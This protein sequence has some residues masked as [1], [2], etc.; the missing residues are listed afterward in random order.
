[1]RGLSI[2]EVAR[3]AG[4]APSAVRYYERAGL[5]PKPPRVSGRRRYDPEIVGRL[6]IIRIARDSGFTIAETRIFVAGFPAGMKPSARWRSLAERKLAEIDATIA[7]AEQM[8]K[9]LTTQFN[10]RCETIEDCE[11]AIV[12]TRCG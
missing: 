5:L 8:K 1:M 10:C 6:Q 11:R 2:G 3:Q 12:G 7:R 4:L 9:L